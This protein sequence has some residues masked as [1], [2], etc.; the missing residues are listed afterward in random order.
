[1]IRFKQAFLIFIFINLSLYLYISKFHYLVPFRAGL[2]IYTAHHYLH[3][4]RL[5]TGGFKLLRA[6]G[7]YDAQWYLRI[8]DKGYPFKPTNANLEDKS[9]MNGLTYAFFPLYPLLLSILNYLV[10]SIELTAFIM[11]LSLLA[12]GF[13]SLYW[14]TARLYNQQIAYKT[15]F[16]LFLFPFSIFYRSYYTEGLFLLL[17]IWYVFFLVKKNLFAVSLMQGLLMVTRPTGLFLTPLTL[18]LMLKDVIKK[19]IDASKVLL[20]LSLIFIFFSVWLIFNWKMTGNIF[21]WKFVQNSWF[22]TGSFFDVLRH[23]YFLLKS[24]FLLPLHDIHASKIDILAFLLFGWGVFHSIGFLKKELWWVSM[25]M[26]IMPI[27]I[28]DTT[29]FTRYQIVSFPIFIYLASLLNRKWLAVIASIFY[30]LLLFLSLYF[31]NW[32]WLG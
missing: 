17:L 12:A 13:Y 3:D 10:G 27:L 15:A 16:L 28:K 32:T 11:S 25:L 19:K 21:Y 6:L 31:V 7:Q 9:V 2:Y 1:M 29:S 24:F 23:N 22:S 26:W 30:A 14:V 20:Y 4:E 18:I 5:G 8:A